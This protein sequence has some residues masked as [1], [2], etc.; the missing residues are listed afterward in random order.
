VWGGIWIVRQWKQGNK[1][2]AAGASL[3]WVVTV[4]GGSYYLLSVPW[5]VMLI[6]T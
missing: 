2:R 1:R 5:L 6:F 3:M 4:V